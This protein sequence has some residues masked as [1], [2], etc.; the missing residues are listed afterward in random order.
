MARRR[1]RALAWVGVWVVSALG[2]AA[3]PP[4]ALDEAAAETGLDGALGALPE[5]ARIQSGGPRVAAGAATEVW[6][7]TNAWAD[8]DTTAARAAGVAWGTNSGLSW[9]QKYERWIASFRRV[10]RTGGSGSTVSIPTPYGDRVMGAPTLECA[11]VALFLRVAF[12]SWYHLP[13]FVQ[14]WDSQGRQVLYAGHF[15]FVNR[16]GQNIGR[17][18][19]FRTAYRDLER[20]WRPGQPWPTDA[21][22][23]R[24]RLGN[25]DAVPHLPEVNGAP[26]GAGAYFDEM[27]L[28]KRAGYF[29]R[30]MLLYFGSVNLADPANLYH[31]QPEAISAGDLLLERWQRQGIGHV[32]PVVRVTQPTQG[33]FAVEVVSGSMPR[34]QPVWDDPASARRYFTLDYT[35]GTGT[36]SDGTPYSRLGGGLRRWRSAVLRSGQWMN[37]ILPADQGVAIDDADDAAISARPARFGEILVVPSVAEQREAALGQIRAAREHLRRYPASCAARTRRED[38]FA[39]LRRIEAENGG[40]TAAQVNAQ[41][42]L[43]EDL[44]FAELDYARSRTCCWNSTNAAMAE[45]VLD[46]ARVE[47]ERNRARGVCA[48]PTVFAARGASTTQDGYRL[49]RDHAATLG[50]AADWRAWSEDEPCMARGNT[51][52]ATTGRGADISCR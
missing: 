10:A 26:A 17:F 29:A 6:A 14:G 37:E 7:V 4:S 39:E 1:S 22:L 50:R 28:N 34:R 16:S 48:A 45:I 9:E 52:D 41:Y 38:A 18:P 40:R 2:C 32:I 15:G 47:L 46:Y 44:V 20:S 11:E 8:T 5:E 23:R 49:W 27:F 43:P 12:S 51:D 42:G 35:G 31:V 13:F 3:D 21:T 19:S 24:Y 36:A 33:R 25:D 30:L